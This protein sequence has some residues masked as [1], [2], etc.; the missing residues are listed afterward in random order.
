MKKGS[1]LAGLGLV[2]ACALCCVLPLIGGMT[3]L[4]VSSFFLTPFVIAGATVLFV[5]AGI[6]ILQRRKTSVSSCMSKNCNC[7]TCHTKGA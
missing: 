3:T 4:A 6:V 2:G 5:L 7:R 1:W